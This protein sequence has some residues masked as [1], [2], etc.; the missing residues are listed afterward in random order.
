MESRELTVSGNNAVMA[1][2]LTAVAIREQVN[3]IQ[4]IMS[5]VMQDGQHYGKIP[6]CGDKPTL[7][8]PGAEKLMLTFRLRPIID[9]DRDI[10]IVELANG[11]REIRVYCHIHNMQGVEMA[12]GIGSCSTME[13]KFRYR[14]EKK[15]GTGKPLPAAYWDLKKSGKEKEAQTLIGGPGFGPGKIEGKW[16]ICKTGSKME[17][18]DIADVYNT[19]LKMA[20]KR[21]F[22]DG[23][24]SALAASDI[25]TQDIED[26]P[27][28][29]TA[30][31]EP[32]KSQEPKEEHK[33]PQ[34]ASTAKAQVPA[35][36]EFKTATGH[37]MD[38][39]EP[40]KG[41]YVNVCIEGFM[42]LDNDTKPMKFS[43]NDKTIIDTI[44]DRRDAGEKI[45]IEYKDNE[46]PAFASSIVGLVSVQEAQVGD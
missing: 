37:I 28:E 1:A 36:G 30:A 35:S 25:F 43:T 17:N 15:E 20:K 34:R 16:E 27:N 3:L 4:A 14:G 18:P 22:V 6:G 39:S 13:T 11:H 41:G 19:V 46:N 45:S 29:T 40:N 26:L 38:V 7:L 9:N 24:L 23:T 44:L 21:A 5:E 12:T 42:R 8:K 10:S 31:S 2:P 32:L 33:A